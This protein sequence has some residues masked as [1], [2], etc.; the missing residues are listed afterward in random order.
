[1][2]RFAGNSSFCQAHVFE[3]WTPNSA[4]HQFII[5][6]FSFNEIS[7]QAKFCL[8]IS[9]PAILFTMLMGFLNHGNFIV[10]ALLPGTSKAFTLSVFLPGTH[11]YILLPGTQRN[12]SSQHKI[13]KKSA[14]VSFWGAVTI[15]KGA[16]HWWLLSRGEHLLQP[17]AAKQNTAR[18]MKCNR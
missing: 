16:C 13:V 11:I 3:V 4:Y 12:V 9:H 1:M 8:Q 5:C 14:C 2:H 10:D 7:Y 18:S 15:C 17:S 6:M